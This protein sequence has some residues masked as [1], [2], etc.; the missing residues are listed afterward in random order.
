MTGATRLGDITLDQISSYFI[1]LGLFLILCA[2][3][4]GVLVWLVQ[5]TAA[6]IRR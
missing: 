4:I 1:S 5:A 3:G 2:I 6:W